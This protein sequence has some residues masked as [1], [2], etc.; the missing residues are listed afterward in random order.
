MATS[1]VDQKTLSS[2]ALRFVDID[3]LLSNSL[4][5]ILGLSTTLARKL[6]RARKLRKLDTSRDTKSLSLYHHIIWLSREGLTILEVGVLPYTQNNQCGSVCLV[7]MTKLRAS[8]FHIFCLFHNE[9]PVSQFTIP[10]NAAFGNAPLSPRQG[11]G[12]NRRGSTAAATMQSN[13]TKPSTRLRDPIPSI[14]SDA[15]YVTNPYAVSGNGTAGTSPPSLTSSG[16][17]SRTVPHPADFLLPS[18]N[19]VPRTA[20]YFSTASD[21]AAQLLPGSHPL[22]LSVALEH[23]AF[24]WDCAHEHDSAR[25]LA[26]RA[27][28]DVYRAQEGM[29]DTEFEDA[30]ELVAVL[31]RMMR[32]TSW[33]GVARRSDI[34]NN[35]VQEKGVNE[36]NSNVYHTGLDGMKDN[37]N[38][39]I[40]AASKGG[41]KITKA[42][43]RN[44]SLPR[45]LEK[46]QPASLTS[47]SRIN[48]GTMSYV[49]Y[50]SDL[51]NTV[52]RSNNGI[53]LQS[54]GNT[55][56]SVDETTG[57]PFVD[58]SLLNNGI[59]PSGDRSIL[60][61]NH[62]VHSVTRTPTRTPP[63]DGRYRLFPG[64]QHEVNGSG[65]RSRGGSGEMTDQHHKARNR[66][67][68]DSTERSGS[69]TPRA[70]GPVLT[71]EYGMR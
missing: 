4:Y 60:S 61:S 6:F 45:T 40:S 25:N 62:I 49:R 56:R 21:F 20:A 22:R 52:N 30:A 13:S 23:S 46:S 41:H 66:E 10:H 47:T 64:R 57:V 51:N 34:E 33:D 29:D 11:N 39:D 54:N 24:L 7:L 19:F 71:P 55:S 50:D 17:A 8:F 53:G 69:V 15:S 37:A 28:R 63:T 35:F 43:Q 3:P 16:H 36:N 48:G 18:L 9:P 68:L 59:G 2:L 42:G 67:G 65:M 1:D 31:G 12:Q 58:Q 70:G 26:R 27:I 44:G 14:T 38:K 32:R 5:Q